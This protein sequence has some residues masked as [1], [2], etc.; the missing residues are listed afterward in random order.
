MQVKFVDLVTGSQWSLSVA[1]MWG[2]IRMSVE[3]GVQ[4]VGR[5]LRI[6]QCFS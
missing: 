2:L 1:N 6:G 5:A 3:R 4:E